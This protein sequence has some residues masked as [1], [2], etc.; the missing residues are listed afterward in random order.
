M[1]PSQRANTNEILA[2][3]ASARVGGALIDLI[4][5]AAAIENF[6]FSLNSGGPIAPATSVHW[7]SP[8]FTF[9]Q[10]GAGAALILAGMTVQTQAVDQAFSLSLIRDIA[11]SSFTLPP[12]SSM[13]TGHVTPINAGVLA[14]IDTFRT[15][16]STHTYSI[17]AM[18]NA[19][20]QTVTVPAANQAWMLILELA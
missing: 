4:T 2:R 19:G 15:P 14:W 3:M 1:N 9:S 11:G 16:G 7:T 12:T 18:N 17:Q 5:L 13:A 10:G 6:Q 20:G 8:P